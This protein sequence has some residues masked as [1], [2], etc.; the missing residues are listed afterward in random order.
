[1]HFGR[2]S[3]E[4]LQL[5]VVFSPSP[6][7]PSCASLRHPAEVRLFELSLS[8]FHTVSHLYLRS[9]A[10]GQQAKCKKSDSTSAPKTGANTKSANSAT[11]KSASQSCAKCTKCDSMIAEDT[12]AL[13]CEKCGLAWKCSDCI[14]IRSSTYDDLTSDSGNELHWFCEPCYTAIRNPLCD[15]KVTQV[16]QKL[17][18]QMSRMEDKLDAKVDAAKVDSLEVMVRGLEARMNDGYDGVIKSLE[19]SRFDVAAVLEQSKLDVSAVQGCVEG[20]LRD[21]SR[22]EKM[23]EEEKEK[24]KTNVII[25][26]LQE[27]S[28]SL[29]DDPREVDSALIQELMHKVS[30]DDV[31][32]THMTRLGSPP[33]PDAKPRPVKLELPSVESRNKVLRNAKKL[34]VIGGQSLGASICPPGFNPTRERSPENTCPGVKGKERGRRDKPD[35]SKWEDSHQKK[36]RISHRQS[37]LNSSIVNDLKCVCLNAQSAT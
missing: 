25:H 10:K 16:L 35:H 11:D 27:P 3:V 32:V 21:Q 6:S 5:A 8:V 24:R 33:D 36:L 1:V 31:S 30:C 4:L 37:H 22:E 28:A 18:Q 9:M 7:S 34:E 19:K 26:G 14:G 17:T 13:N 23:E 20:V 2:Q 15:D 12:R 29:S